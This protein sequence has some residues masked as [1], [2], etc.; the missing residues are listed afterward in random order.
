MKPIAELATET[1]VDLK[2][3][4]AKLLNNQVET[5]RLI[6]AVFYRNRSHKNIF[7]VMLDEITLVKANEK[8]HVKAT[9]AQLDVFSRQIDDM[10][11]A[12]ASQQTTVDSFQT[13]LE[14]SRE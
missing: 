4:Q 8:Q 12:L 6:N 2:S 1:R 11:R 14:Q 13:Q 9:T 7:T 10:Q 5:D 3:E